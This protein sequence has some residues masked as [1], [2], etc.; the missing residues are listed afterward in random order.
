MPR[1][2]VPG[3]QSHP[4]EQAATPGDE[5]VP[6]ENNQSQCCAEDC[7]HT[8]VVQCSYCGDSYCVNCSLPTCRV[9]CKQNND[10]CHNFYNYV[11]GG[12]DPRLSEGPES[13]LLQSEPEEEWECELCTMINQP[14]VLACVA[15][16]KTRGVGAAQGSKV[17]SMCTLVNRP[18]AIV[19]ELCDT[20]L[21]KSGADGCGDSGSGEPNTCD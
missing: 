18:G 2:N 19:C 4:P 16:K 1:C 9:P 17:C 21:V 11:I 6:T 5:P 3:Q 8:A 13:G 10:G 7:R 12:L 14:Y 20:S 15:C